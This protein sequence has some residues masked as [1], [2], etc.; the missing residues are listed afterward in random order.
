MTVA[1]CRNCGR[2]PKSPPYAEPSSVVSKVKDAYRRASKGQRA[3]IRAWMR[4][5]LSDVDSVR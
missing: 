2:D 1:T 4:I 5:V 3:Q